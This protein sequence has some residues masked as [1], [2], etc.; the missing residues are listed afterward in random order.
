M[1]EIGDTEHGT[2]QICIVVRLRGQ[3]RVLRPEDWEENGG[4]GFEKWLEKVL[5]VCIVIC[6][7][8][9]IRKEV[10]DGKTV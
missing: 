10:R 5:T 9:A 7:N 4:N 6:Y 2:A 3:S 8:K 1:A